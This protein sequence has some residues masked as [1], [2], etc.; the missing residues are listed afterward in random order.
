MLLIRGGKIKPI[1]GE[2]MENGELLIGDDGKIAAIGQKVDA[3]EGVEVLD[4]S[5]CLVTPGFIDAHSHICAYANRLAL[6]DLTK[7]ACFDD[8]VSILREFKR[9][10]NVAPGQWIIGFGH[11]NNFLKEKRHPDKNLL[12]QVSQENPVLVNHISGHMG[13]LNTPALQETGA[14]AIWKKRSLCAIVLKSLRRTIH[15]CKT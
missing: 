9:T 4:A 5:G 13:A 3:P 7:A 2:E 10:H 1:V 6:A 14:T 12:D 11:D 15:R 8:I